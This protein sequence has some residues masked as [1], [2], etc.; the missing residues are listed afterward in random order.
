[1]LYRFANS[2]LL[3]AWEGSEERAHWLIDG[4]DLILD[5]R[6]VKRTG[7]EGWFD[8]PLSDDDDAGA[9]PSFQVPRWKQAVSI[10]LGFLPTNLAFTLVAT[11][12]IPGWHDVAMLP[13]L[14]VTTL[15]M[16][17]TMTFLVMPQITRMLRPWLLRRPAIR[18]RRP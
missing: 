1:M 3:D 16:A 2:D 9:T 10:G 7:I 17:P 14:V 11:W 12:L 13:K 6:V 8:A 4:H 18:T 5:A 15:V